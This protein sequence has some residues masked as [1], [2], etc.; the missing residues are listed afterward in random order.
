MKSRVLRP[1][2]Q[3]EI[4]RRLKATLTFLPMGLDDLRAN[5]VLHS[6][7]AEKFDVA[8]RAARAEGVVIRDPKN[9]DWLRLK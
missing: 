8:F 2:S 7:D 3:I 4:D 5:C 6:E 9:R 1:A